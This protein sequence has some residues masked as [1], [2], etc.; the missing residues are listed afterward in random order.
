M[1]RQAHLDSVTDESHDVSVQYQP[2]PPPLPPLRLMMD[3]SPVS[4]PGRS[5]GTHL[6]SGAPA[7]EPP[8]RWCRPGLGPRAG[9]GSRDEQPLI[10]AVAPD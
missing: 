2:P 5:V 1:L 3:Q 8:D 10:Y 4:G 6:G 7:S 9:Q